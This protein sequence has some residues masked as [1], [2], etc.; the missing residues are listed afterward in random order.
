LMQGSSKPDK[1]E[2]VTPRLQI[3]TEF[4][5]P[6]PVVETIESICEENWV[7]N[8]RGYRCGQ[9]S[10]DPDHPD[11][12]AYRPPEAIHRLL[13]G[14]VQAIY[15]WGSH[16][17]GN[18]HADS[19]YDFVLVVDK[20]FLPESPDNGDWGVSA[21]R[22]NVISGEYQGHFIDIAVYE[23]S[24]WNRLIRDNEIWSV[25]FAFVPSKAILYQ[26]KPVEFVLNKK[27]L[28][29]ETLN[30]CTRY[31]NVMKKHYDRGLYYKSYKRGLYVLQHLSF[32]IEL[33]STGKLSSLRLREEFFFPNHEQRSH[34]LPC[35]V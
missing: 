28:L 32:A 19:D 18:N 34:C 4:V 24:H 14:K 10:R 25:I 22:W 21:K 2:D 5:F 23:T 20:T 15:L 6:F 29:F 30:S 26:A 8:R 17:W 33:I 11:R 35:Q 12:R 27:S 1:Q 16:L 7:D 13:P 31:R 9:Y 3:N